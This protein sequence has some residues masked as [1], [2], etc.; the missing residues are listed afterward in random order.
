MSQKPKPKPSHGLAACPGCAEP[1]DTG[2][3]FCGACGYDL[4]AVP[5]AEAEPDRPTVAIV[6]PV[7][8]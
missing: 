7:D 3:R 5:A 6:A 8:W 4:T 1:L 2:D